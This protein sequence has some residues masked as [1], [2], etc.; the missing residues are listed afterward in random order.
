M[1]TAAEIESDSVAERAGGSE[2]RAADAEPIRFNQFSRVRD[3]LLPCRNQAALS[4]TEGRTCKKANHA[5]SGVRKNRIAL[6]E[7]IGYEPRG[8]TLS[9]HAEGQ[10]GCSGA[11]SSPNR[12][13]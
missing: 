12:R 6:I 2:D 11:F 10:L 13:L 9:L 4:A 5:G 1:E 3:F 7:N 8:A